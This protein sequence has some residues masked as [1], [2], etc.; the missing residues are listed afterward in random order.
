MLMSA[1]KPLDELENA[2]EFSARHIGPDIR[3]AA[4]DEAHMLSVIGA[5]S[6]RA[7]IE[8]IVP[9]AIARTRP[10]DLPAPLTEAAALAELKAIAAQNQVLKSFIGQG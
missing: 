6:R 7:L 10:M 3:G 9:R 1:L 4:T 8:A 5:A 2:S